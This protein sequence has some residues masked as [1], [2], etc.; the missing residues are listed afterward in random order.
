MPFQTALNVIA[1]IRN[2]MFDKLK[3]TPFLP[4]ENALDW[5]APATRR[6]TAVSL[7]QQRR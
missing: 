1:N 4:L 3:K 6:A 5:I 2:Q 7:S